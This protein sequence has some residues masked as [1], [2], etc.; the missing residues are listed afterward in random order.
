MGI[1]QTKVTPEFKKWVGYCE[2]NKKDH[3]GSYDNPEDFKTNAG[4]GNYTVFADL[5]RQNRNQCPGSALVRF[6][7]GHGAD[8]S[9]W[10]GRG[11]GAAWRI[12]RLHSHL[13]QFLQKDGPLP[14]DPLRRETRSFS[15]T[16]P[17][18]ITPDM[19]IKWKTV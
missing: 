10:G 15:T 16:E 8:P 1:I 11:Q 7:C 2:K 4:D 9:V 5:Y 12:F 14:S 6:L 17:G 13:C 3:L 19:C 18:F